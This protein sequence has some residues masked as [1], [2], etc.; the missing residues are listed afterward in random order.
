[1][2]RPFVNYITLCT[3]SCLTTCKIEIKKAD[4]G[5]RMNTCGEHTIMEFAKRLSSMENVQVSFEDWDYQETRDSVEEATL[6]DVFKFVRVFKEAKGSN[7]YHCKARFEDYA[8]EEEHPFGF[9]LRYEDKIIIDL[10]STTKSILFEYSTT[11]FEYLFLGS[12]SNTSLEASIGLDSM[13]FPIHQNES[14]SQKILLDIL[15]FASRNFPNIKELNVEWLDNEDDDTICTLSIVGEEEEE[16]GNHD[17]SGET[18]IA[19]TALDGAPLFNYLTRTTADDLIINQEVIDAF[20]YN[21]PKIKRFDCTAHNY[22][23]TLEGCTYTDSKWDLTFMENLEI[24]HVR[25]VIPEA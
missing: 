12:R 10:N 7:D 24:L 2:I 21:I 18:P 13:E 22:Q 1:M 19:M 6:T 16:E 4:F 17:Y 14:K 3:P 20:A 11:Q 23:Q 15:K 9:T 25:R 8:E 5:I